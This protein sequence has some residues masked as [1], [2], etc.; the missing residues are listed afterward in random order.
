[1]F[2]KLT[3]TR[4]RR[5]VPK[6]CPDRRAHVRAALKAGRAPDHCQHDGITLDPST[7][8]WWAAPTP[9]H[10]KIYPR[11]TSMLIGDNGRIT[12]RRATEEELDSGP[13][14]DMMYASTKIIWNA[15]PLNSEV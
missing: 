15:K 1:M 2:P 3:R 8:R 14:D 4:L 5:R 9:K 11:W 13:I 6:G 10:I 12:T 7:A